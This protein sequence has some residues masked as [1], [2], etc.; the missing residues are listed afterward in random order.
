MKKRRYSIRW[1]RVALLVLILTAI[2][3][4]IYYIIVGIGML[5][6]LI[7]GPTTDK[8]EADKV[9]VL[10]I[11]KEQLDQS[12]RMTQ[13]ID[14]MMRQPMRL[15]TA[16]I[17]INIYDL[18]TEQPIYSMHDK[19]LLPPA[20][21]M[22]IGTA[23]AALKTLG[24]KHEYRVSLMTRG[25]MHGDTLVG[26]VLLKADDDPLFDD[27][28]A[29][30]KQLHAK[31]IRNIRGNVYMMLAREDTLRAHP[32]AKTW[33]IP[34]HKTPLLLKGKKTVN[35]H[36]TASLRSAGISYRR[37]NSVRPSGMYKTIATTSH[38]LTDVITPMMIHSSNIKADA[39]LYHLDY[40]K[41]MIAD[42]RIHWDQ[43]HATE[44]FWRKTMNAD[45]TNVMQG[46]VF[47]DGSGLSPDSRLTAT[48]LVDM[49]R[50]AYKDEELR[51]YLITEAMATPGVP[52]RRG[53]LLSR[54]AHP[55]Y[56][57]RIY[58]K[59][60][61]MTTIGGSSLAGYLHGHDGHWYAFSIINTDSPVAESRIFQDR[62]CK[63]MMKG[64][65]QRR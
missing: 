25:K 54:M 22:K 20:S 44:M 42:K 58:V 65:I 59:T 12:N 29:L 2:G 34:F 38:R 57:D 37:D 19:Q 36:L 30:A 41:G 23:I 43:K 60:G 39:V 1:G 40:K 21:C 61:T 6:C 9:E 5:I 53:S 50:Y 24:M 26:N 46:F 27:M 51:D 10:N 35:R 33:D 63:T 13:L 8:T 52:E 47:N 3:Y 32:T 55:D 17:A 15:D 7:F 28:P 62:L 18:T 56:R 14:S 64:K 16:L 48:F 11:S 49:L 4:A 45:S 31:G